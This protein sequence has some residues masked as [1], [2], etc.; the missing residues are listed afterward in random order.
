MNIA[1]L[2]QKIILEKNSDHFEK[3]PER[4]PTN[5]RN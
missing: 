4:D 3:Q 1:V 2:S 5:D